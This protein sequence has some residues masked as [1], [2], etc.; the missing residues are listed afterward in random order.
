VAT[1]TSSVAV[2]GGSA[3]AISVCFLIAA[4]EGYD[5]Q[6]FGVA[7]PRL[8]PEFGLDAGQQGWAASIA[9]IG[10]VIGAFGGGWFADRVGR[11]PVLIVSVLAFGACSLWTAF[12]HSYDALLA[13]R[14]ATGLGFGG[15]L[16]NLI[17]MATELS[18]VKRRGATTSAMFCGMPAGGAAVALAAKLAGPALDW[19]TIFM[20]GGALPLI[21]VPVILFL[22]PE[23]RP[24]HDPTADRRILKA[25]FGEG[26]TTPTLLL[27]AANLL[28]LVV[29]YL[30]LNW[31]PTLVVAKG[32]AA[33][34]GAAASL[35]FNLVGVVGALLLGFVVDRVGFRWSLLVTY[36]ALA[37]VMATMG[38]AD[39]LSLIVMLSGAAGFLVLGAQYSLYGLAP[40]LYAPQV[41]AAG[42]G[43]AVGVGRFGS[44]IGPLLAGELRHAGWSAGQVLGA[45]LPVVL[46]AGAAVF[47]LT[48]LARLDTD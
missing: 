28:T 10:L 3:L 45:M 37:A 23:T 5:I 20:V 14:F 25:L 38:V 11:K 31:L 44:I 29:L 27:W 13:A 36:G 15:A 42:A 22:L 18:S 35:A 30:M 46:V 1:S 43:A 16:P 17:A 12:T 4:L 8:V 26:R 41:R 48:F 34:D 32:H 39:G 21:L 24:V 9:M 7:A 2:R 6:A 19:R 33:S 47:V 40:R